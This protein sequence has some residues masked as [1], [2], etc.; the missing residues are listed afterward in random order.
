MTETLAGVCRAVFP[1]TDGSA[2]LN[3]A[4]GSHNALEVWQGGEL[5]DITP[6]GPPALL[7]T[8]PF[9]VT[10]ASAV[11]TVTHVAHGYA[12][13]I[14]V[15]TNGATAGGGITV[16]GGP[17]TITVINADSYSF[18]FTSP[19]SGTDATT[20]GSNVIIV[21]QTALAA[22][23]IDGTGSAGYGTGAYGV[24]PYGQGSP[25]A[26]YYPR[27][28]SFGAWGEYLIASNRG[29]GI[30][31]WRNGTSVRAVAINSAPTQV[32]QALVAPLN[33]GSMLFALGCNEEVS[34]EFNPLCIRHSSVRN[35]AQWSTLASGS[36]SREY[37]LTGGGRIVGG[38][39]IG[40]YML[41]W[42]SEALFLGTYVGALAQPWRFDR[43]GRNCG[44]VGPNAAVVVGQTAFW[45][46]PDRQF[47][48]YSLGG[49]PTPITCPIRTDFS[50]FL[51]ASQG[52]KIVAS[53]NG[54]YSEVRFD[55]PDS[56]DGYENSRYMALSVAGPDAG[57]W[58][59]GIM[60]RTAFVDAGPS[61]YPI[62]VTYDGAAYFH[63]KGQS[64][65]GSSFAWFIRTAGN[66]LDPEWCLLLRGI[67]PDFRDQV[68]PV[69]VEATSRFA[70]QGDAY[71]ATASAMAP[72]DMKSDILLTGRIFEV[73]FYGESS[74]T[75]CRLGSPVFD[76]ERTGKY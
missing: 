43:V 27:T 10:N 70:P 15:K 12:D 69:M 52:D 21:P 36:T 18:T 74:P 72:G 1:W 75:A 39:M 73:M 54:E 56:R 67:W 35:N 44:L 76:V 71:T 3:V 68:G 62:G 30:Y 5:F 11:I 34:G 37:V 25:T 46:S 47:F 28:W 8:D 64:A 26:E 59:R 14:Q 42:T 13:A 63:E 33:G 19:A 41:V 49:Q 45:C 16:T 38:R 31:E 2:I 48:S 9:A 29:G 51:A 61:L 53:S 65:D 22:G 58:H 50:D 4:F 20:G 17:F 60:A 23:A 55:Y 7:G 40:P 66:Y 24:G 57:A 6:Y 32:T